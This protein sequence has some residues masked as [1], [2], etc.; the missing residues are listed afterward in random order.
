MDG[1]LPGRFKTGVGSPVKRV[2]DARFLKGRGL[3]IPNIHQPG[4]L[5]AVF[6]RSTH[7]HARLVKT[8]AQAALALRSTVAVLFGA[9]MAADNIGPL[10]PIWTVKGADGNPMAEPVRWAI[11]QDT[12]RHVGEPVALVVATTR[13]AAARAAEL[14][15]ITYEELPAVT[16]SEDAIREGA[17]LIHPIAPSN[18]CVSVERGEAP[19]VESAFAKAEHVVSLRLVNNRLA[20]AA[21]EP[22]SLIGLWD[23]DARQLT[24]WSGAQSPH[25]I[26]RHIALELNLPESA[27]RVI[28]PD[29]GGGFGYKGKHYCEETAIAWAARRLGR[30]VR[31]TATRSECFLADL[32]SRDHVTHAELAIDGT[33]K[34]LALRVKT[35]A[36][37]GAYTSSFGVV[38]PTGPYMTLLS[39][40]YVIPAIHAEVKCVFTNT[41]PTD[42]YRGAGRP[43][44]CF[45]LE[46]LIDEAAKVLSMDPADLRSRNLIPVDA[47]PYKTA[48]GATYD[49]GNFQQVLDRAKE[50]ARYASFASREK[51]S[52]AE[53][54]LRGIGIGM[55][56]E[57]S[58]VGPSRASGAAGAHTGFFEG[59][60]VQVDS[61]GAVVA[62]IGTHNH[63]Q[64]HQTTYAQILSETL[65]IPFDQIRIVEGDTGIVPY[66]SGT[67]GSRSMA[68]GGSA[69]VGAARKVINK[70][71]KIAAH[72]LE[73]REGDIVFSNGHYDLRGSNRSISFKEV[74]HWANVA[75]NLPPDVEPG[76]HETAFF[77]PPNLAFSNG[78]HIAEVEI[79]PETGTIAV[80]NFVAVDDIGT[81]INPM[82][83]EGQVHGGIAQGIGQALIE[84][85][86][87][88]RSNGQLL[89]GSF[90]DYGIPRAD[91][92]P[93]FDTETDE[94]QPFP[95]NPLGAKGCG[96]AGSIGAPAAIVNAVLN[97]LNRVGVDD[98][99][100]PV[101][102]ERVWH[103]IR[104]ASI[105]TGA[106]NA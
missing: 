54:K 23:E 89:S 47:M 105:A 91:M 41:I 42:A 39:E 88:D 44:A 83:V 68:V 103:A 70:G 75:H 28:S 35:L 100:M 77:D 55:F 52:A 4:A 56:V 50:K 6:V 10:V 1:V 40:V 72:M 27:V 30:P 36:N 81:V 61:V 78:C 37:I 62:M 84:G 33:G 3:Y 19:P 79:D 60:E 104:H 12:V 90:M 85:V 57:A 96:E 25:N 97:A 26:R 65:G 22:R 74:A 51:A 29:I 16:E 2:E 17:P 7:A 93:A 76:L 59:A 102:S 101:T 24:L 13:R 15:D 32:Q 8:D 95:G 69:L 11:A 82:I 20:G 58:G 18:V 92:L 43:E 71:A 106:K 48:T 80:V 73:G 14:V 63:G 98:I 87:Y 31:W 67:Y 45:V 86:V 38:V 99:A 94:S 5:W 21:M 66:G 64:G 34:F 53:G 9:D 49:C 46:R